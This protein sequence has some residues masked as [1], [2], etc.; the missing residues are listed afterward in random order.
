MKIV[1]SITAGTDDPTRATIGMIAAKVAME[2]GHEVSIWLF[3]EAVVIA[4][5][6]IYPCIQGV[7]M[8]AMK[9]IMAG[10]LEKNMA[11]SVCEA[12]AKG[13]NVNENNWVANASY[14]G[15]GDFVDESLNADKILFY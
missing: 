12:C 4:N 6:N 9:D 8:P 7:N 14:R 11:F 3:G 5:Q 10:L 2:K 13:R 1:V 15:M